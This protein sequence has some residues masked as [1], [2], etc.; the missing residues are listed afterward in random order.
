MAISPTPEQV[1]ELLMRYN[2]LLRAAGRPDLGSEEMQRVLEVAQR[3]RQAG[4]QHGFRN[5]HREH[6]PPMPRRII[7]PDF[8]G[9]QSR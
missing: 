7:R 2:R 5:R 4:Q 3:D 8:D 1:G 9:G 6:H